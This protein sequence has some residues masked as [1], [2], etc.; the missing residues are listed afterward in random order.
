MESALC[1]QLC[2]AVPR[3]FFNFHRA[4]WGGAGQGLLC[5]GRGSLFF[6]G[7]GRGEHSWCQGQTL[8]QV[9]LKPVQA[10]IG[11]AE[12]GQGNKEPRHGWRPSC[13]PSAGAGF[14]GALF[15]TITYPPFL[16]L[17]FIFFKLRLNIC[18]PC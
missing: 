7:V 13:R 11:Q 9:N 10:G 1:S 8:S 4:G 2:P 15:N 14:G 5:T 3:G 16:Q 18:W 17:Q 12:P 6:R